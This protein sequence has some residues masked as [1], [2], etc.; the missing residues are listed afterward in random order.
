MPECKSKVESQKSRIPLSIRCLT[1]YNGV[2]QLKQCIREMTNNLGLSK[3][4]PV[5]YCPKLAVS[6]Q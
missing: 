1:S 6:R 3:L 2:A 4:L 5:I